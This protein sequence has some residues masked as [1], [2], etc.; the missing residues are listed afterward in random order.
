MHTSGTTGLP[1]FCAQSHRYFLELGR[2][3]ADRMT[4]GHRDTVFAPL[5]LF[6]INPLGYGPEPALVARAAMVSATRFLLR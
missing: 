3:M 2:L 4:L 6:H 1:K 5:P